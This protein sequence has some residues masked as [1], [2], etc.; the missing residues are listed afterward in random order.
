MTDCKIVD[1]AG[2]E[3]APGEEGELV[4]RGPQVMTG[5]HNLP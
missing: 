5:Y 4:V 1:E 3:V 2:D